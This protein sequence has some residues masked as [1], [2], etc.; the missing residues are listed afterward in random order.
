MAEEYKGYLRRTPQYGQKSFDPQELGTWTSGERSRL[1]NLYDIP[2]QPYA[3]WQLKRSDLRRKAK[4]THP[5]ITDDQ[6]E[7]FYETF[8]LGQATNPRDFSRDRDFGGTLS[9]A[10]QMISNIG[11]QAWDISEFAIAKY[12]TDDQEAMTENAEQ[13]QE[14]AFENQMIHAFQ[15][16]DMNPV[17]QFLF[18]LTVSAPVM[19]GVMLGGTALGLG[20]AKAAGAVGI[21]A[22]GQWL[23]GI[24]GFNTVE[25]LTEMGFNYADIISDP[26]VREKIENALG[27]K[28]TDADEEEIKQ[29][30]LRIISDRA[31]ESAET[32]GKLNFFNPLNL[33]HTFG[34]GRLAKLIKVSSGK[35][36]TAKRIG[37]R[38]SGRE[39]LEE[40]LQSTASQYT[41]S[42][43]KMKAL[44]DVGVQ[45]NFP[46]R[47]GTIYGVDPGQVAYEM[48]MGGFVGLPLGTAQGL[49]GYSKWKKGEFELDKHGNP[50]RKGDPVGR[51]F[52]NVDIPQPGQDGFVPKGMIQN[53]VRS[54]VDI[55]DTDSALQQLDKFRQEAIDRGNPRE[56]KLIDEEIELI[57]QGADLLGEKTIPKRTAF[58]RDR[59]K[60]FKPGTH[61]LPDPESDSVDADGE[62]TSTRIT[63]LNKDPALRAHVKNVYE[64]PEDQRS[65]RDAQYIKLAN[66]NPELDDKGINKVLSNMEKAGTLPKAGATQ[67]A[68]AERRDAPPVTPTDTTTEATVRDEV[69]PA[70]LPPTEAGTVQSGADADAGVVPDVDETPKVV[71]SDAPATLPVGEA[72]SEVVK[73]VKSWAGQEA[74][75]GTKIEG[76]YNGT[77][78]ELIRG[79][80]YKV[81]KDRAG[82]AG[83][84]PR[85]TTTGKGKARKE[86]DIPQDIRIAL[87]TEIANDLGIAVPADIKLPTPPPKKATT[88]K[89]AAQKATEKA[90]AEAKKFAEEVDKAASEGAREDAAR[91][92][93]STFIPRYNVKLL[94]QEGNPV[95]PTNIDFSSQESKDKIKSLEGKTVLHYKSTK[96][97][98]LDPYSLPKKLEKWRFDGVD[99]DGNAIFTKPNKGAWKAGQ[100]IK[101]VKNIRDHALNKN[102]KHTYDAEHMFMHLF[103]ERGDSYSGKAK[104]GQ[105]KRAF[106]TE[107][108]ESSA[109]QRVAEGKEVVK[110]EADP[111]QQLLKKVDK[112]E[113]QVVTDTITDAMVD[114]RQKSAQL[115]SPEQV[116][117]A[118]LAEERADAKKSKQQ[119]MKEKLAADRKAKADAKKVATK[120]QTPVTPPVDQEV[121]A[122]PTEVSTPTLTRKEV[123]DSISPK[124]TK[125][126][127]KVWVDQL[128]SRDRIKDLTL[129]D[130][131]DW[132]KNKN[133]LAKELR[134]DMAR[135]ED[136]IPIKMAPPEL[137]KL[138]QRKITDWLTATAT[139]ETFDAIKIRYFPLLLSA[140]KTAIASAVARRSGVAQD[141]AIPKAET[142]KKYSPKE[143]ELKDKTNKK[144]KPLKKKS[145]VK[146]EAE[147]TGE[148]TILN[149]V[150]KATKKVPYVKPKTPNVWQIFTAEVEKIFSP[151]IPQDSQ[152]KLTTFIES[153]GDDHTFIV[154]GGLKEGDA[155]KIYRLNTDIDVAKDQSTIQLTSL[156]PEGQ[157]VP[158]YIKNALQKHGRRLGVDREKNKFFSRKLKRDD[159]ITTPEES[160][161]PPSD[162]LARVDRDQDVPLKGADE[163]LNKVLAS[164]KPI[165]W[166]GNINNLVELTYMFEEG[167]GEEPTVVN[168]EFKDEATA[169][170]YVE[171]IKSKNPDREQLQ[172][173][174]DEMVQQQIADRKNRDAFGEAQD[175][176]MTYIVQKNLSDHAE[177]YGDE[178]QGTVDDYFKTSEP[179]SEVKVYTDE[180]IK[181]YEDTLK[182][183]DTH[184]S[185]QEDTVT[186]SPEA[187]K[188]TV[189]DLNGV[190]E[191]FKE[192]FPG[193]VGNIELITEPSNPFYMDKRGI[194]GAYSKSK[195]TIYLVA[196]NLASK[197]DAAMTLLHEAIGHRSYTN[198]DSQIL[199]N[200][201]RAELESLVKDSFPE[202]YAKEYDQQLADIQGG[203]KKAIEGMTDAETAHSLA[204][205]EVLAHKVEKMTGD[206]FNPTFV[207]Q[208]SA[209]IRGL[210]RDFFTKIGLGDVKLNDNDVKI[211][212]NKL[213]L[214]L[215]RSNK[216]N[217]PT[218]VGT[219]TEL[220]SDAMYRDMPAHEKFKNMGDVGVPQLEAMNAMYPT[221]NPKETSAS[222]WWSRFGKTLIHKA[223]DPFRVVKDKIGLTEYMHMRM[224][225]REDGVMNVLLKHGHVDVF[226]ETVDGVTVNQT[227]VD[228]KGRGLFEIL[229][230]LGGKMGNKDGYKSEIDRFV[231]WVAYKR[232]D[233][234]EKEMGE[235]TLGIQRKHIDAAIDPVNGFDKGELRDATTG[236]TVSRKHL[237]AK[238]AK[239]LAEW[240]KGIVD[241]GIK[242]GLFDQESASNWN[243]DWYLPF[244]RH[245]EEDEG[246]GGPKGTRNYKSLAG[247]TGIKKLKGSQR[248]LDNPLDNLVKN[249]L[250]IVSASLKNDSALLT[251][252]QATKIKDPIS[253]QMLAKR[254]KYPSESSLRVIKDGKDFHYEIS[255]PLLYDA[256]SSMNVT[257]DFAG[258]GWAVKA[259][260][261]FT[262]ITTASPVFKVRN[263]LRDTM[264]AAGTTDVGFN[265]LKNAVGGWKE[266]GRSEADMLVSGAY[267]QFGS[268]RSDDPNF[269]KKLLTKDMRS[270]FIGANPEAH[271]GYMNAV[272]KGRSMV[273]GVWD[274]YQRWGDKL[275]N[276][277]RAAVFKHHMD[278]GDSQLKA[279]Y[280][281]RDLLDFTLHGGAQWVNLVT[282]LTPFANAMLQGKYK[283]GR[284]L[285]NN[286]TPVVVVSSAVTMASLAEYFMYEDNE[287]WQRRQDWDKDMFWWINIPGTDTHFRM[288]KPH[289]FNIVANLAWRGLDMARKKD[290]IHGELLVSAVKSVI[291]REFNMSPIPQFVKPFIEV[292]FNKNFF[293]DR[294][295]EPLRF[296]NMTGKEKR[297]L[298]TSETMITMSEAFDWAGVDLSPMDMEHVVNGYFGWLGEM[299]IGA[300]D[301]MVS[302]ARDFPDRPAQKFMDN[303]I[304]RKMFQASPIRNT[305]ASTAFYER[306]KDVEQAHADLSLSKKLQDWDRYKEI[307]EE[308]KD[309]LKWK[310]FI[311]KKQRI[312]NELN[313]R[314]R[315]IRFD[316]RMGADEKRERMD[317]LYLLRNQIMDRI[318]ESPAL[319]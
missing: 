35:W 161:F 140:Q 270:G 102:G 126:V 319:R 214:D 85:D 83:V 13:V 216:A 144:K 301:I 259:K 306:M 310:G 39:A 200:E 26:M 116:T 286:P 100:T 305:K 78:W 204:S 300:S 23:A 229:R 258:M 280:E 70:D 98:A 77:K 86:W 17:T 289:E 29:E 24:M 243:T 290:P 254:V 207:E 1:D 15:T 139:P 41:A 99:Y 232:A 256:L 212:F 191:N 245:F 273:R 278:K 56:I 46:L 182:D 8:N 137:R 231:A 82:E 107:G 169:E 97:K 9:R 226:Q 205:Q 285:I 193:V 170:R 257:N 194:K 166:A 177:L 2:N 19:A 38:V 76:D 190:I 171:F 145:E 181:A 296:K 53:E 109:P 227:K 197:E 87:A 48:L 59:L 119:Q 50:V 151:V 168:L 68:P 173:L 3:S 222:S 153:L 304:L 112:A 261:L 5:N 312:L 167:K 37:V 111:V 44:G 213:T 255:D 54:I 242:M 224:V 106:L 183:S 284:A 92:V 186:I 34:V 178:F 60:D 275:E 72:A 143:Q 309:L 228:R 61:N 21:G 180:E 51:I 247:Q 89:T 294:P 230:P 135:V 14:A 57:K 132:I 7:K 265:L 47:P 117:D 10:G 101:G 136:I 146:E 32:V 158:S 240:N 199:T 253:G 262:R 165:V 118:V 236:V 156:D 176:T 299:I 104:K 202:E 220:P 20:A 266:L 28:L 281:A 313:K 215:M 113:D 209:W 69:P 237:Y 67:K 121:V 196:D 292:G 123:E 163:E 127:K 302:K 269:S 66:E 43:A 303:P 91:E 206:D 274:A 55:P 251:L 164:D 154:S 241:F 133:Y 221:Y 65:P 291:G 124:I 141:T 25:A 142:K 198:P 174:D 148:P 134:E 157:P 88:K 287:E 120:D 246:K 314:I 64:I 282:S 155:W 223:V 103:S 225:N 288:P 149:D 152:S 27:K 40:A 147:P 203:K 12:I 18:D 308:K 293:F 128:M 42:E 276:A 249:A 75:T 271:D 96:H 234:L 4:Q 179:D 138:I 36:D 11:S 84:K 184:F 192:A 187:K 298:Y 80:Q 218:Y 264:S 307:Y 248:A 244:F 73:L 263:V 74:D 311:K 172:K 267:L 297:D 185:L 175:E 90:D 272:R 252:E 283:M 125:D 22:I 279:A 150:V 115:K 105:F 129:W 318:A 277:N 295:I 211:L 189:E 160:A 45:L 94:D 52:G 6:L 208:F 238:M 110:E 233:I 30:A 315:V 95:T 131:T 217:M 195:D 58:R 162:I 268:I 317:Q 219:A 250:H 235:E 33:G 31:G 108:E 159:L 63:N 239:E 210:I 16:K 122:E 93:P 260:N 79:K 81:L 49:R 130:G 201:K 62:Q 188:P 316:T 114:N 71:P